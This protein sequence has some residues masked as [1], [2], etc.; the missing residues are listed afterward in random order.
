MFDR[1]FRIARNAQ[2]LS[3]KAA[4]VRIVGQKEVQEYILDLNRFEQIFKESTDIDGDK[5][6]KYS[7]FTDAMNSRNSFT[8]K[9]KTRRKTRGDNYFLFDSGSFFESFGIK[10]NSDGFSIVAN[11]ITDDGTNIILA[12]GNVIGLTNESKNNLAQNIKPHLVEYAKRH[13]L[14]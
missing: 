13:L 11:E 2:K 14:G 6:G 7:A 5:L 9:G 1:L 8:Y 4:F 10:V 12:F 3:P